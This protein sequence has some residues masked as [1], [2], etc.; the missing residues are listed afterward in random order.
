V[1]AG[2]ISVRATSSG[3]GFT[4]RKTSTPQTVQMEAGASRQLDL[5]FRTDTVIKGRVQ[6]NGQP[7]AGA[8]VTFMPK[9]GSTQQTS[10]TVTTDEQGNYAASGLDNGEYV[11]MVTDIQRFTSYTTTYDVRGSATFDISHT[12]NALRGRVVEATSGEPINEARVQLR[13]TGANTASMRFSDRMTATDK[14]GTF[15]LDLVAAGNYTI[16]ADKQGYGNQVL[17]LVVTDRPADNVEL[18][19]PRNEGIA[20]KVVDSRDGHALSAMLVVFDMQGRIVHEQRF[21]FPGEGSTEVSLPLAAGSYQ[22]TVGAMGY[23]TRQVSLRS[24][25]NQTV[26]LAPAGRINV[27]SKHSERMRARLVDASGMIYPR[28]NA[29][30]TTGVLNPDPGTTMIDAVAG[31]TYTLQLLD[32]NG[33][34]VGS[35]QVV[36]ADGQT[37]EVEI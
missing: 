18:R 29:T 17:D 10:A 14:N 4:S 7:L 36:V 11:V 13:G 22:A 25:S 34:V 23:G 28:W 12:A 16:T 2:T 35:K 5:E 27:R 9:P 3:R 19:L 32:D 33:A 26:S 30:P 20:L 21:F 1:P 31:G 24:P 8:G 6:R 37:V 15:N